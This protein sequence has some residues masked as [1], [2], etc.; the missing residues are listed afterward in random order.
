MFNFNYNKDFDNYSESF[1][2]KQLD[3]NTIAVSLDN[4]YEGG[5]MTIPLEEFKRMVREYNLYLIK[6]PEKIRD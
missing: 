1:F 4:G 2:I 3:K 5:Y 6:N